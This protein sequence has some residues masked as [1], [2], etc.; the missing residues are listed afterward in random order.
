[1]ESDAQLLSRYA[2]EKSEAA[3]SALVQRHLGLVYSAALREMHGNEASAQDVSQAVFIEL[4]KKAKQ[5]SHHPSLAGWLY[6][7]V[8]HV[9]SNLRRAEIRRAAREHQA[10]Q[11][12]DE[13]A[14]DHGLGPRLERG[15]AQFREERPVEQHRM[16][17]ALADRGP[18]GRCPRAAPG[19]DHV[20][21]RCGTSSLP[22]A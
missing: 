1:M 4:A 9:S 21:R 14:P 2:A 3:F 10:M 13:P 19:V 6:T 18:H 16:A 17:V 12:L 8:R 22:R 7:T 20:A 5:L 11:T 15:A